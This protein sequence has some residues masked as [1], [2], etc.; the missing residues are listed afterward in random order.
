MFIK[1]YNFNVI[2]INNSTFCTDMT[3]TSCYRRMAVDY[4]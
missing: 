2:I 1:T 4:E 3:N